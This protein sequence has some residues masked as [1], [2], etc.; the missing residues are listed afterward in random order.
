VIEYVAATKSGLVQPL[1][2]KELDDMPHAW[3]EKM[4]VIHQVGQELEKEQMDSET[5]Q[6]TRNASPPSMEESLAGLSQIGM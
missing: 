6:T 3:V 2:K 5:K 4:W 1:T